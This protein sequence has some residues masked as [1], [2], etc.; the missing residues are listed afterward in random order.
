[1]T[2]KKKVRIDLNK[3]KEIPWYLQIQFDP[4]S[5]KTFNITLRSYYKN[6][7]YHCR[8]CKQGHVGDCPEWTKDK[9]EKEQRENVKKENTKTLMIGDS[10]IWCIIERGVMG[11]VT[12]ING[13]EICI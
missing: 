2:W 13:G 4:E 9:M 11:S 3:G 8:R 7:P 5:G 6:Q 12:S 10:N 1:M